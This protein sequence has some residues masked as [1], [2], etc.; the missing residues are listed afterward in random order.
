[1]FW[2]LFRQRAEQL[3]ALALP[4]DLAALTAYTGGIFFGVLAH[5]LEEIAHNSV[6]CVEAHARASQ[7]EKNINS[8]IP[9]LLHR[10]SRGFPASWGAASVLVGVC[11]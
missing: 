11:R 5:L 1:M 10:M 3:S 9:S 8:A 4:L 7:H 6:P 2:K